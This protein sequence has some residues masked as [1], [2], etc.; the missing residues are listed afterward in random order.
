MFEIRTSKTIVTGSNEVILFSVEFD[1]LY[2]WLR[3]IVE[4]SSHIHADRKKRGNGKGGIC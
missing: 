1:V 2:E 3:R 4:W